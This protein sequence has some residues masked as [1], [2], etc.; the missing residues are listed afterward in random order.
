M[1]SLTQADEQAEDFPAAV[2]NVDNYSGVRREVWDHTEETR[3]D[4]TRNLTSLHS[5]VNRSRERHRHSPASKLSSVIGGTSGTST[6]TRYSL[7]QIIHEA[8][9]VSRV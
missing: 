3:K 6:R 4:P 1:S 5:R 2:S 8:Q 7:L 9:P